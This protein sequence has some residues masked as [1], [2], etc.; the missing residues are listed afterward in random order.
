V[1]LFE[2]HPC[3][4]E[5]S[6][7]SFLPYLPYFPFLSS[8]FSFLIFILYLPSSSSFLPF[9]PPSFVTSLLPF[10]SLHS[11]PALPPFFFF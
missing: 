5:H 2:I 3:L 7:P 9:L 10:P 4:Y 1:G 11:L 8:L 6:L